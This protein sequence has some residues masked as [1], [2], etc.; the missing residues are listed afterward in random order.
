MK[1]SR[2]EI[3]S[4]NN[5]VRGMV[6]LNVILRS[7]SSSNVLYLVSQKIYL[8]LCFGLEQSR[9]SLLQYIMDNSAKGKLEQL[10][11]KILAL[12]ILNYLGN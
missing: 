10:V 6:I 11:S 2:G 3:L 8:T 12:P 9:I 7:D 4:E 5:Y 1:D